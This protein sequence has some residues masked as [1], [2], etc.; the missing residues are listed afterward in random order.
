MAANYL[1]LLPVW[2]RLNIKSEG[3]FGKALLSKIALM[4]TNNFILLAIWLAVFSTLGSIGNWKSPDMII[5]YGV[6]SLSIGF[7]D[8]FGFYSRFIADIVFDG[9]FDYYLRFPINPLFHLVFRNCSIFALGDISFGYI[10]ILAGVMLS[11]ESAISLFMI[12]LLLLKSTIICMIGA[13]FFISFNILI[14]STVFFLGRVS[15]LVSD[16]SFSVVLFGTY[17]KPLFQNWFK[18]IIYTIVPAAYIVFMPMELIVRFDLS[19]FLILLN[20]LVIYSFLGVTLFQVGLK[21]YKSSNLFT[22]IKS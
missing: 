22:A 20:V 11:A 2:W 14:N 15:R 12:L 13:L 17:P 18:I 1:H 7:A 6:V 5:L 4:I 9:S 10:T 8:F 21:K 3:S 16:L 19:S